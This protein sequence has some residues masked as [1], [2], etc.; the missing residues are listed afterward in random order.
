MLFAAAISV[1][2]LWSIAEQTV[3]IAAAHA[4]LLQV[5]CASKDAPPLTEALQLTSSPPVPRK[6]HAAAHTHGKRTLEAAR[7]L[8][9]GGRFPWDRS[10]RCE[11]FVDPGE[12]VEGAHRCRDAGTPRSRSF[13]S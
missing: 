3:D 8:C 13:A 2:V 6:A 11:S 12:W 4:A 1:A 10:G 7:S 9:R 5:A